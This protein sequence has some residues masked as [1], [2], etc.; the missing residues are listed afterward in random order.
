MTER[1]RIE[2]EFECS[3]KGFWETFLNREY[4]HEMFRQHMKF[5]RWELS[6]FDMRDE[7]VV[8]VVE[9]EPYVGPLPGPVK[10]VLGEKVGYQEQ[11]RLDRVNNRYDFKIVP[12]K[13][14]DKILVSGAQYTKSRG[15]SRCVRIFEATV[16]IKI[17][18]IGSIIEK[19]LLQ[20]LKRS[21]DVGAQFTQDYM[22]RHG[23]T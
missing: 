19:Q 7:E 18:A 1:L 11:G 4:N 17:F 6:T 16:E 20:D 9:V 22:T 2:H 12:G 8:R 10:K 13:L 21:Y 3:E 15:E 14:K 5:P 23:V